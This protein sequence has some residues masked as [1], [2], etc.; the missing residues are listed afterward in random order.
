MSKKIYD[1]L[2]PKSVKHV[3]HATKSQGVVDKSKKKS[4]KEVQRRQKT[5]YLQIPKTFPKK[6]ILVG[7]GV[8]IFLLGVYFYHTLPWVQ[9][10][11]LPK[12]D[13]LSF[14]ETIT[15]DKSFDNVDALEKIIPAQYVEETVEVSQDFSATGSA[16]NGAKAYG[17]IKVYNKVSPATQ[18]TLKVGTHFLSDSGKYFITLSK[19]TIPA[20][21]NKT[22]GSL[23]VQVQAEEAGA[24]SNIGPS[25][26]SVPKLSGTS[27]YYSIWAES[28]ISM[29]GGFSG[30]VKKVTAEDLLQ[31]KDI[32]TKKVLQDTTSLL[33]S[34]LSKD[35]I[36]LDDAI[37]SEILNSSSTIKEGITVDT[38]TQTVKVKVLALVFK[39][40]D[41]ETFVKNSIILQLPEGK[42]LLEK[43]LDIN[44]SSDSVDMKKGSE[45]IA[46]KSSAKTY[47][48][49]DTNTFMDLFNRK[50]AEQIKEIVNQIYDDKVAETK[51]NFWPF[52][53]N[54]APENNNRI[55]IGL[56]L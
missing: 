8:V 44:Y 28:L 39:Q 16:V 14:E 2:P 48:T 23:E 54:R 12:M 53:V 13:V 4:R 42:S 46:I 37:V 52:W 15:A 36:L 25:K 30:Q 10:Q 6:E 22:P 19:I 56:D 55:K 7:G 32:V 38:F 20:M 18:I 26:F 34:K 21:Q 47:Y 24:D 51:V 49:I 5:A 3:E 11:I 35:D 43:S 45:T 9:V 40:Q 27:S 41:L 50:S 1:I 33:K 31:A 17:T 29:Q